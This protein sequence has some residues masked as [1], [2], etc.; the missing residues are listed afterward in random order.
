MDNGVLH[1]LDGVHDV[2]DDIIDDFGCLNFFYG[3]FDI[4]FD[5]PDGVLDV[6][7]GVHD[8]PEDIIDDFGDITLTFP[9][10]LSLLPLV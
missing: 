10:D 3:L 1:I 6:L 8:V 2:P 4:I 7:D 5:V 9:E